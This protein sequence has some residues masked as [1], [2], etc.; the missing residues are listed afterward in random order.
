MLWFSVILVAVAASLLGLG[1]P[2]EAGNHTGVPPGNATDQSGNATQ[3]TPGVIAANNGFAWNFYG[4]VSGYEG[5]LFF[6]PVGMYAAFSMVYEGAGD[7][8]AAQMRDAFGFESDR[9]LRH[10]VTAALVSSLNMEDSSATL[11]LANSLWLADWFEPYGSYVDVI[12]D[13]YTADVSSVD[14]TNKSTVDTINDWAAEKTRHKIPNVLGPG[15]VDD[16]TASVLMNAIYFKGSWEYQFESERTIPGDFWTGAENAEVDF[17]S[18]MSRFEYAR[19]DDA[20]VL[21]MP[22]DGD[23]LS[24]VIMLPSDRDG[25]GGNVTAQHLERW[26]DTMHNR[27]VYVQIPKFEVRTHYPLKP[28]LVSMGVVDAFDPASSDL[29]GMAAL[30]PD[31][32]LYLDDA[33]HDAY[34]KV[35]EEGTEAAAVTTITMSMLNESLA[36]EPETFRADHP[37]LFLIQDDSSGAILFMGRVTDPSCTEYDYTLQLCVKP[38]IWG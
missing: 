13:V 28:L 9:D 16:E 37:F 35:N 36:P 38:N 33:L 23:R 2:A 14:F 19:H 6:S 26:T 8:T 3:I 11:T 30:S 25:F 21:R 5:N 4:Q 12:R 32:T 1:A 27:E 10:N 7:K 15:D 18:M 34:V 29:S 24:M 20:Q 22:Y 31:Q 17:M